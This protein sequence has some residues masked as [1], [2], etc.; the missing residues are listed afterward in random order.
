MYSYIIGTYTGTD[1]NTI[2]V[3]AGGIGYSIT[4]PVTSYGLPFGIGEEVKIYT[5]FQVSE[6]QVALYGF[7]SEADREVFRLLISVNGVGPKIAV[8]ILAA[9]SADDFKFAVLGGDVKLLQSAPGVGKK[10]AERIIMELKDKFSLEETFES[11]YEKK[12]AVPAET[13]LRNDVVSGLTSLGFT[14]SEAISAYNKIE[15][16]EDSTVE[17]VLGKAL[18][19]LSNI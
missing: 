15:I 12:A 13:S 18:E 14:S 7:I 5:H 19:L 2:V 10:S 16:K 17:D 11:A 4:Y 9:I 1:G 8:G 3:E 6:N